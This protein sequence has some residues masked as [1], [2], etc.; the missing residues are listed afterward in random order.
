MVGRCIIDNINQLKMITVFYNLLSI[1]I[2]FT[3]LFSYLNYRYIKLPSTIGIM[4][5]SLL[6]SIGLVLTGAIF[7]EFKQKVVSTVVAVDFG[8]LLMNAMLSFLLFA[9]AV[10]VDI[11]SLKKQMISVL[12]FATLGVLLSTVII[13]FCTYLIFPLLGFNIPL[14]YCLLFGALISP[15]DPIAVLGIISEAKIPG[16]LKIKI[17]GESLFNDGV[18]VVIFL[19][20]LEVAHKGIGNLSVLQITSLFAREAVGGIVWGMLIGYLGFLFLRSIDN[21][22]V[23]VLITLA[24]VMGGYSL[25]EVMH[26]SGPLAMVVAGIITG[27]K[28]KEFAMSGT[29][30]DYLGKFWELI[31]EILNAILFLLMGFEMLVVKINK[32]LI[33]MG[34][35]AIVIVLLAR[36]VSVF[37]P[38]LFLSFHKTYEKY[39]IT[40]LTWGGLRGGISVAMALSIPTGMY[41]EEFLTIT[42]LV[43]IFSILVQGLTLG[44]V[45]KKLYK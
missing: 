11:Q 8:H 32:T 16:D 24:I 38:V 3:A 43:V 42:Y 20:I 15:T 27:N 45:T 10:H 35:I 39:T 26:V 30:R 31:D 7:P 18:G 4:L 33:W 9:G 19:S 44:K 40:M 25:A 28:A 17:A 5:I 36:I 21:Y 13:G 12:T 29:T 1:L 6:C 14:I 37:I 23:E 2:V 22:K 34:L 41:Q